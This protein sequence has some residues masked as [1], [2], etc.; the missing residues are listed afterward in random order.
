MKGSPLEDTDIEIIYDAFR[1][2]LWCTNVIH[3]DFGVCLA[4]A[5]K[6]KVEIGGIFLEKDF[7][8][9]SKILFFL[10]L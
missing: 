1:V 2:R 3:L 6:K 8:S 5:E 10:F 4:T 7:K 9:K